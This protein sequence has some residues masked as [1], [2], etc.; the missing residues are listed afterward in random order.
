[1]TSPSVGG[2]IRTVLVHLDAASC[3]AARLLAA[4]AL[5][6]RFDAEVFAQFC[7]EPSLASMRL[8]IAESPAALL[9]TRSAMPNG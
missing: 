6:R 5:A 3:A 8:A 2:A 4:R 9:E 1:M 7:V